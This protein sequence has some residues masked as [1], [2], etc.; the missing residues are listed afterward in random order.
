MISE[1]HDLPPGV[2]GF[3]VSRQLQAEDYRDVLLPAI[4]RAAESSEVRVVIVIDSF[5][6]M[7]GGALWEDLKIGVQHLRSFK[8]IALVTDIGWMTQVTG[9]F[10]WLTPGELKHFP[11]AHRE[12]AIAWVSGRAASGGM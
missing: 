3:Q 12:E 2:I 8:R 1:L 7:S 5:D 4:E 9:L 6:G 11:R 10:G